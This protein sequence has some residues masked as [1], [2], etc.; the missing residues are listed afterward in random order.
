MK[1]NILY[2]VLIIL[3][4]VN[5][6]SQFSKTHYIPPVS[7]SENVPAEEQYLYISTP[8]ITPVDFTIKQLGGT[9]ISGVVSRDIPYVYNIG[10][11]TFTQ[12]HVNESL[13]NSVLNNKGFIVEA[14]DLV[15]VTA[16][17]ICGNGNHAGQKWLLLFL[18]EWL[19]QQ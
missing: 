19:Q 7:G 15:Y 17:I 2:L 16:R 3:L 9:T 8:S 6:Y 12:M 18:Q 1:K 4:S 13:I 10:F 14:E 11:G 5:C